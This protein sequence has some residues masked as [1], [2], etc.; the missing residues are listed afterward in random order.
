MD[1]SKLS[2]EK[3][4]ENAVKLLF[5]IFP[6]KSYLYFPLLNAS[7]S[8]AIKRAREWKEKIFSWKIWPDP[9][10]VKVKPDRFIL[11]FF[12]SHPSLREAFKEELKSKNLK[13]LRRAFG[14]L[15]PILGLEDPFL[16]A[17]FHRE[18]E[19]GSYRKIVEEFDKKVLQ[20]KEDVESIEDKI[21][22]FDVLSSFVAEMTSLG[23][24]VLTQ[25]PNRR[26]IEEIVR[27]QIQKKNE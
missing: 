9:G 27:K 4:L 25:A 3:I 22:L 1:M 5:E 7:L 11:D 2:L 18:L 13:L 10:F 21:K 24:E 8:W 23:T 26:I 16:L 20:A 14:A 6:Q 19:S 15:Y 12:Q 17:L